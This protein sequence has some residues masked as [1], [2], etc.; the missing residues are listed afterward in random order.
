MTANVSGTVHTDA[1]LTFCV[2]ASSMQSYFRVASTHIVGQTEGGDDKHRSRL[3]VLNGVIPGYAGTCLLLS[4]L[5]LYLGTQW[6]LPSPM[7]RVRKQKRS[8]E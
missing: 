3:M 8:L 2:S 5:S 6:V 1:E 4:V 7:Q